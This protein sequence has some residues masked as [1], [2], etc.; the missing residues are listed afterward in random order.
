MS[1]EKSVSAFPENENFFRWIGT[2]TGKAGGCFLLPSISAYVL[3]LFAF[4]PERDR[5]RWPALPSPARVPQLLSL[6]TTGRSLPDEMFPP[7]HRL[8]R[9][10]LPR[11]CKLPP[12]RC[13]FN[14]AIHRP[15]LFS[16]ASVGQ[17]FTT[18]ELFCFRYSP[19]WESRTTR[20]P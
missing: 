3:F 8:K 6:L 4:R 19:F 12:Q 13:R 17:P 9:R 16:C 11:H 1:T 20:V 2:I 14:N 18:S 10:P 15:S 5:L 7:K